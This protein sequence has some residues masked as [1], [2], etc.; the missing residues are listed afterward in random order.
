MLNEIEKEYRKYVREVKSLVQEIDTVH[1]ALRRSKGFSLKGLYDPRARHQELFGK[2]FTED[3][4][5]GRLNGIRLV[6]RA[7]FNASNPSKEE[8]DFYNKYMEITARFRNVLGKDGM[9]KF[10]IP[11]VQMG[12]LEALSARGLLGLYANYLGS[13]NNIDGVRIYGTGPN[14]KRVLQS[15]GYWKDLYLSEGGELTMPSG[16]KIQEL[17][18]LKKKAEAQVKLGVHEDGDAIVATDLEMDTLMEGG[19]FSRFNASR[20]R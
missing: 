4:K 7:T 18:K 11:H 16:R 15:F 10:Y 2:M 8:R 19:L 14:G 5:N 1:R 20:T 9:G 13:T 6:D 12:N 17:R 3:I